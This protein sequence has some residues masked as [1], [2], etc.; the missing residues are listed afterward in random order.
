M[1]S[2]Y[3]IKPLSSEHN[4]AVFCCDEVLDRYLQK[5]A[6][7][8]AR[9]DVAKPYV[10]CDKNSN[11][12]IGYYTLSATSIVLKD[13]PTEIVKK[14]PKYPNLPATLIGRLGVDKNYRGKRLVERLLM[15]ALYLSLSLSSSIGLMAV[16]VDA[17]DEKAQS[18]Y[19]HYGFIQ[20]PERP[21]RLFLPMATISDMFS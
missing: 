20:F 11:V 7:Q 10:L 17:K 12:V 16:V 5:Q 15:D 19:Q 14:L 13:L 18:F 21:E 6:R 2:D 9:R 8:D 1:G 3:L 4:R